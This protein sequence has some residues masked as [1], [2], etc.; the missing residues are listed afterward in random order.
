M[1]TLVQIRD[2]PDDVYKTLKV[3]AVEAGQSYSEFLRE[4]LVQ[5]ATRPPMA[6]IVQRLEKRGRL[7]QLD[8][9]AEDVRELRD[10]E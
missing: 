5:A 4:L 3:R 7:T 6:E 8:S 1:G 10:A 9:T 2:V